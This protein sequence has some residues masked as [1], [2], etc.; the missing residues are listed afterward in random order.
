MK[1]DATDGEAVDAILIGY[2]LCSNG[3]E[4]IAARKHRLVAVRGEWR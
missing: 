2:G 4:G 3:I 1:E